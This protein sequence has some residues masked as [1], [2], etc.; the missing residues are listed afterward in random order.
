MNAS[1]DKPAR[2]LG[3]IAILLPCL[4]TGGTEVATLE[5]ALALH[6]IGYATE[7]VVYF[8]EVDTT[9]LKTFKAAGLVVHLLGIQR[10]GGLRAQWR[11]AVVLLSILRRGRFDAIW[12]QYMTP[13]LLP[14]A[15]ARFA[16]AGSSR[17]CM[18]RHPIIRRRAP[19]TALAGAVRVRPDHL[20][21][22]HGGQRHFWD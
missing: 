5:T 1:S 14:L 17:Q 19:A 2:T 6:S 21:F 16:L 8:D 11:L 22:S 7:V 4:L 18:W 20:R 10:G 15:L 13:T 12:V 9:M 3:Q